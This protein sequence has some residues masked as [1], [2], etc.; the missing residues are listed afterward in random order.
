[1]QRSRV[2]LCAATSP[3]RALFLAGGL[4]VA[5]ASSGCGPRL[6]AGKVRVTGTVTYQAEPL[7]ADAV[8]FFA[9]QG[10][11]SITAKVGPDGGFTVVLTPGEYAVSVLAKDG[12]DRMD[13]KGN[14]TVAPSLIPAKYTSPKTSGLTVVASQDARQCSIA[15]ER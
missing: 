5:A 8:G 7:A 12:P 13:E 2:M 3:W 4:V 9:K 14:V 1:M 6:P 10:T 11:E 15:L